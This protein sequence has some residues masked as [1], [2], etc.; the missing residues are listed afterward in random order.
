MFI[1]RLSYTTIL[2]VLLIH[3]DFLVIY[4]F[5]N[6]CKIQLPFL[7]SNCHP[8]P[9]VNSAPDFKLLIGIQTTAKRYERRHLLR[10]AYAVQQ[11]THNAQIDIRFVLCNLTTKEERVFLSLEIMTYHDIIILD[12][13]E[14]TDNGKTYT[15]FSSLPGMFPGELH[16]YDY[17]MKTDDDTYIRLNQVVESLRDTSRTDTYWGAGLPFYDNESPPF[18]LGMGYIL[19]W[20][21]VEWIATSEIPRNEQI[22]PED[23]LTGEWLNKGGKAK[24]RYNVNSRMYDLQI[25][26]EK[27]MMAV[28]QL[29]HNERWVMAFEKFNVTARL[30]SSTFYHI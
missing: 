27:E 10:M 1:K 16:P 7:S 24:N 29:K 3:L 14:K 18:M 2:L 8:T 22:G 25:Q 9:H 23:V 11:P 13:L 5:Q 26:E 12:C 6:P 17:V 28:H 19:S 30:K 4:I 20:D 21:L 15:Y